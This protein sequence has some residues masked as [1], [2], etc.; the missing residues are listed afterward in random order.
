MEPEDVGHVLRRFRDALAPGGLLLD[1]QV[2]RPNPVVELEGA[3][4][5]EIDGG[6]LFATADSAAA[7]VDA[8]V[9]E[10]LLVKEARDDHDVRKHHAGG[11]ELVIDFENSRRD[12][13]TAWIPR[14]RGPGRP[15][16]VRE[17]C[18]TRR[19]RSTG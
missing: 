7:A 19:L 13:P 6:P 17:R 12:L 8:T 14:L 1:L 16:A 2:I 10:G 4:L 15:C 18:R 9:A 11:A 3:D 5:C